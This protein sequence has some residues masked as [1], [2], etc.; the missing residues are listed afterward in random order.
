MEEILDCIDDPTIASVEIYVDVGLNFDQV[1]RG[2]VRA[3][4]GEQSG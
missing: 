4:V 3:L 2:G 1:Q